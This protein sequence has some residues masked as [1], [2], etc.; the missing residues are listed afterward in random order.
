[1]KERKKERKKE[2]KKE[3]RKERKKENFFKESK[4][5]SVEMQNGAAIS[6]C[7]ENTTF[8]TFP[9]R[10]VSTNLACPTGISTEVLK[11]IRPMYGLHLI[12]SLNILSNNIQNI[13]TIST[14]VFVLLL[15]LLMLVYWCGKKS[16]FTTTR[17]PAQIRYLQ[18]SE[19][20]VML[21]HP[22]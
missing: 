21:D 18:G 9:I 13:I 6:M 14:A 19:N 5:H 17:I 3:G 12:F 1:M 2:G 16:Q 22:I 11:N 8:T 7:K 10:F 4:F 15:I 20:L